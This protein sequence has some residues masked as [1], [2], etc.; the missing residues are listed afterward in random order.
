MSC[1]AAA[2]VFLFLAA[3]GPAEPIRQ[4]AAFEAPVPVKAEPLFVDIVTKAKSLKV[5]VDFYRAGVSAAEGAAS[6][7]NFDAFK[8][9][10]T[11]LA[12]LDMKGHDSLLA[13]GLDSDLKCILRG[14]AQD[15]PMRLAEVERA[16]AAKDQDKALREMSYLLNDNVEVILAPPA[17]PV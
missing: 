14:I 15:L 6:L 16:K 5:R 11:A 9:D 13:R 4:T 12:E 1:D 2:A 3:A 17:P 10:V 8:A 7:D